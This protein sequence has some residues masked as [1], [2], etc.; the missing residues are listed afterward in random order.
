MFVSHTVALYF[1]CIML[2]CCTSLRVFLCQFHP[3]YWATLSNV[4][5]IK[6]MIHWLAEWLSVANM[7]IRQ[8]LELKCAFGEFQYKRVH[9]KLRIY[10]TTQY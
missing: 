2:L 5:E 7:N 4:L 8:I 6:T 3:I 1:L 9:Y 10:Q